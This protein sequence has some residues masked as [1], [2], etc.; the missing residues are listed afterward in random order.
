M[1]DELASQVSLKWVIARADRLI[2]TVR[3]GDEFS[4]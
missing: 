3:R 2:R 1:H 4:G